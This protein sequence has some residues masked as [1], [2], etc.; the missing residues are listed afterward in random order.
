MSRNINH[1]LKKGTW[2]EL[3]FYSMLP[4]GMLTISSTMGTALNL[5]FTDV[6][7]LS[8]ASVGVILTVSRIWDAINDPMMGLIVDKTKTKWGKC[9][10][11]VL[12]TPLPLALVTAFLF[13]PVNF[14]GNGNFTYVLVLYLV[15]YAA[16]TALDIP[17]QG[18]TPL[19]FPEN[20]TRVKAV[21]IGNIVGSLGTI[22]PSVL[23]FTIAGAW[24]REREKEGY[25]FTALVFSAIACVFI[26]AS[27][28]GIK[29]KV[30][31]PPKKTNLAQVLKIIFTDKKMVILMISF[32]FNAAINLGA[33]F[34]PYFAKWNCIG[35]LPIESMSAWL[36]RTLGMNIV[37]TSEGILTPVL[38][39]GSG[40]SYMLSMALIPWLLKYMDKR[41][42][43][44]WTSLLGAAASVITYAVGVWMVPY[45][46][47]AGLVLYIA[48]RFFTNFP[49]GMCMVLFIAM[50][51]DVTD[52]LEMRHGER[53]EGS[54]F[55]FKSLLMKMSWSLFNFIM[56]ATIAA[57]GYNINKMKD[58]SNNLTEKLVVS[59]TQANVI[60][61]VNYTSLMN[62]IFFMLTAAA[63]IGLVLQAIPL[64]FY[65]FD[66]EAQ[67]EKLKAYREEKE[68]RMQ[69]ELLE[70]GSAKA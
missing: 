49:V 5:Y 52:D 24:G 60:G 19:L 53:L 64:F 40:I 48:L 23:F 18:M 65:Q 36:S 14:K 54:V 61:G 42:L 35:V 55:S 3:I 25:F 67:E 13:F 32:I 46:T 33:T 58:A 45:N 27:F 22:L 7:G 26:V 41:K 63:A 57:F 43:M 29:E 39:I 62:I 6:L 51:S 68:R 2:R 8:I 10:P 34:L 56:L 21:S 31:I 30:Y 70:A 59:T 50:F 9:R 16:N 17:F 4:F 11:Y 66:E 47:A 20:K 37:L 12:W 38:Q 15:F 1:S 44:I 28:F 69:E